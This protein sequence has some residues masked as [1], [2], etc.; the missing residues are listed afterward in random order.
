MRIYVLS[1]LLPACLGRNTHSQHGK[2]DGHS[3]TR[4]R[5][6]LLDFYDDIIGEPYKTMYQSADCD[7][8]SVSQYFEGDAWKVVP[9]QALYGKL[10]IELALSSHC[11]G[12]Q[13]Q[14][15]SV[16]EVK[17][18][19]HTFRSGVDSKKEHGWLYGSLEQQ[20]TG[21]KDGEPASLERN[22]RFSAV[23][24]KKRNGSWMIESQHEST[25]ADEA[26]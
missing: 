19:W 14:V 22:V 12:I 26:W 11:K 6:E 7:S 17:N 4:H 13:A 5:E 23:L 18:V 25:V 16:K 1:L 9:R 15:G 2:N 24:K 8:T 21:E 20:I 10:D 3:E